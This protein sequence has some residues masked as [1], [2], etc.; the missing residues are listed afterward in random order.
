MDLNSNSWAFHSTGKICNWLLVQ[1]QRVLL[2]FGALK[3]LFWYSSMNIHPT[4]ILLYNLD[5]HCDAYFEMLDESCIQKLILVC[6]SKNCMFV[7]SDYFP[8]DCGPLLLWLAMPSLILIC[9]GVT[10]WLNAQVWTLKEELLESSDHCQMSAVCHQHP[11]QSLY[12]SR[13]LLLCQPK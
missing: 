8:D 3:L 6:E 10:G 5:C 12:I 4:E 1:R 9:G 13:H 11:H 2:L 7:F